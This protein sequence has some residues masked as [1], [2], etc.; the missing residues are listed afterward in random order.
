MKKFLTGLATAGMLFGALGVSHAI[1]LFATL[2]PVP[3]APDSPLQTPYCWDN[4]TMTFSTLD[5]DM[6]TPGTQL[7]VLFTFLQPVPVIGT[8][9]VEALL[10]ITADADGTMTGTAQPLQNLVFEVTAKNA[11]DVYGSGVLLRTVVPAFG[12]LFSV[13][14]TG[15]LQSDEL[16][17]LQMES[18][19]IFIEPTEPQAA[20][21]SF[22]NIEPPGPFVPG[23]NMFLRDTK[24]GGNANFSATVRNVIPEPGSVTMLLSL[25]VGGGLA[26]IRRR[27]SR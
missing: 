4:A 1:T 13:G 23:A 15:F 26:L 19:Y 11:G 9:T 14:N 2:N 6:D 18:D 12:E 10:T 27:R 20:S 24:L 3:S 25:G 5:T 22:S 17:G 8:N 21:W 16:A 7:D